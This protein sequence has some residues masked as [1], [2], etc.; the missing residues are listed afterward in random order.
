MYEKASRKYSTIY[1]NE[2]KLIHNLNS[3]NSDKDIK[4]F[5]D[6]F[7]NNNSKFFAIEAK[8]D[9]W[10]IY[11]EKVIFQNNN[12]NELNNELIEHS[13]IIN[14]E[15]VF[16]FNLSKLNNNSNNNENNNQDKFNIKSNDFKEEE[17]VKISPFSE[18]KDD[19]NDTDIK[20]NIKKN[21][22]IYPD[23][24]PLTFLDLDNLDPEE[25][26]I[27]ACS[28]TTNNENKMYI[29]KDV[30]LSFDE[31]ALNDYISYIKSN[32]FGSGDVEFETIDETAYKES[33]EFIDLF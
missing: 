22:Y 30:E 1:I 23:K 17:N 25:I 5:V 6:L 32:F 20:E 33:E 9:D 13:K 10:F 27:A 11:K 29:W 24:E 14:N 15:K 31:E 26:V 19:K 2:D 28:N 7:P 16:S 8:W 21:F 18:S 4:E 12:F 3:S